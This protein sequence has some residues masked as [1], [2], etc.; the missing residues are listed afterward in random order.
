MKPQLVTLIWTLTLLACVSLSTLTDTLSVSWAKTGNMW[1]LL[2]VILLAPFVFIFFG[3]SGKHTGL[4]ITSTLT[5]SLIVIGPVLVGLIIFKEWK[6]ISWPQYVGIGL[7]L[8]GIT[9]CA[10]FGKK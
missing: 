1:H 7:V 9:L 4:A 2:W 5:N 3:L 8:V 6:A 10:F